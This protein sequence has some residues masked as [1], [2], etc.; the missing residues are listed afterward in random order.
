MH[1]A[2]DLISPKCQHRS[3]VRC[4]MFEQAP[5]GNPG[6]MAGSCNPGDPIGWQRV[7]TSP[8]QPGYDLMRETTLE[9]SEL[10]NRVVDYVHA[11]RVVLFGSRARGE[12][13]P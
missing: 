5:K 11:R 7:S 8:N 10:L 1:R 3:G 4:L 13:E 2:E 12:V 9:P 6:L